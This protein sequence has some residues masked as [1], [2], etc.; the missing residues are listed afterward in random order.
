MDY[1]Q[2][3]LFITIPFIFYPYWLISV[4]VL[5]PMR[6]VLCNFWPSQEC[7][8]SV[9]NPCLN[10]A[11]F[12]FF[13]LI[14]PFATP[15]ICWLLSIGDLEMFLLACIHH[16]PPPSLKTIRERVP[17]WFFLGKGSAIRWPCL[18]GSKEYVM[19]P[20]LW[21]SIGYCHV[22]S[23]GTAKQQSKYGLFWWTP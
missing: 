3:N 1:N 18:V 5:V 9:P 11:F 8:F 6:D 2:R 20:L 22:I 23:K 17:L 15:S 16:Q 12:S 21:F 19:C 10:K 13:L 7:G 14:R 4:G